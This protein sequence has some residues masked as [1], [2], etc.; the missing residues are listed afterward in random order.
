MYGHDN[1]G[2]LANHVYSEYYHHYDMYVQNAASV[3][4][5]DIQ[6]LTERY[7]QEKGEGC[8]AYGRGVLQ[9]SNERPFTVTENERTG[10]DIDYECGISGIV[11]AQ[12]L[13]AKWLLEMR[14]VTEWS[15]VWKSHML[16]HALNIQSLTSLSMAGI[17]SLV[18]YGKSVELHA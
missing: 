12:G 2:K 3:A 14:D 13:Q 6:R 9:A 16:S 15:S 11:Y 4:D 10:A 17:L 5:Y 7:S 1:L 18:I 8:L